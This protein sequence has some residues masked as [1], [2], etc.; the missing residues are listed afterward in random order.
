[1]KLKW[2]RQP[3]SCPRGGY[4]VPDDAGRIIAAVYKIGTRWEYW[5]N[6]THPYTRGM[7]R[8]LRE[9]KSRISAV[10]A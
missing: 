2:V 5:T 10:F 9:A 7:T 3:F 8:T 1:M 4:Y 6:H